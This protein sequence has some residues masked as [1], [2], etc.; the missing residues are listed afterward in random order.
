MASTVNNQ[1]VTFTEAESNWNLEKLYID[2]AAAKGKGLT[3]VEKKILRGLLCGYSPAEIADKVYQNSNSNTVRVCLSNGLYKYI[4]ELLIRKTG[5]LIKVKTWSKVIFLLEKAGYK[6]RLD[7]SFESSNDSTEEY[8]KVTN[9]V[10]SF[11]KQK[12]WGEAVNVFRFCGRT[13]E[14]ATIEKWIIRDCCRLVAL[15]GMGG[16]G[17]TAL[18]ISSVEQMQDKFDYIIWRSLLNSPTVEE[19]LVSL[20][21]FLSDDQESDLPETISGKISRLIKYLRSSRCLLILDN[22]EVILQNNEQAKQNGVTYSVGDYCEGYEGY[23]ELFKRVGETLHQSCLILNSQEKPRELVALEGNM[24]PV[25]SLQ[26]RGLK[27]VE[28]REVLQAKG[29]FFGSED[30]WNALITYYGGNSQVLKIAATTIQSLFDGNIGNFLKQGSVVYSDI[31]ELLE[32]QFNRLSELEKKVMYWLA[33]NHGSISLSAIGRDI[34][35][36]VSYPELLEAI[37]F[38]GRRSLLQKNG[39][40]FTQAPMFVDYTVKRLIEQVLK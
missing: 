36:P 1:E 3:P 6:N 21:H 20:I 28:A 9:K 16:I 17:K 34:V 19:T 29:N 23:G 15:L 31:Y 27:P 35:S 25:R 26:L 33:I 10:L 39:S 5:N 24:L 8:Q 7:K 4:E 37:E 32:Q 13:E 14:L 12:D 22:V 40:S 11:N 30:E 2:L 38:L 18:C